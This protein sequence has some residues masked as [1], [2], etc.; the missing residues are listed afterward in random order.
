MPESGTTNQRRGARPGRPVRAR[1]FT[2]VEALVAI[3]ITAIAS[4]VLLLGF[5]SAVQTTHE[6]MQQTIAQG[7][8]DQLADEVVGCRYMAIGTTP[9]QITLGP[10]ATERAAGTRELYNDIDDF[11][12]FV[13][14]PPADPWGVELGTD[15][16]SG[17]ERHPAFHLDDGYLDDWREEIS[18]YYV[19]PTDLTTP[20]PHGQVSDYRAVEVAVLCDRPE[21]G[22]RELARVRRVVAYVPSP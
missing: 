12:G 22:T 18:V 10:S 6:A 13:A 1:G 11:D 3:T 7:I 14:Q 19:D 16:Q 8:A 9:Y 4:S 20:L 15:D 5:T 21:G 2:L 17:D